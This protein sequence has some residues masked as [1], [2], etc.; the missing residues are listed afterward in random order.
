MQDSVN[1]PILWGGC[2]AIHCNTLVSTI[3]ADIMDEKANEKEALKA[4]PNVTNPFRNKLSL[5]VLS[6]YAILLR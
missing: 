5:P 4:N 2:P 3:Q 1:A 6:F